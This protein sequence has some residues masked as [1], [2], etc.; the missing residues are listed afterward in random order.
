MHVCPECGVH[1]PDSR[2]SVHAE[3]CSY[4]IDGAPNEQQV[5]DGSGETLGRMTR[6]EMIAHLD[7]LAHEEHRNNLA[8][9]RERTQARKED[10]SARAKVAADRLRS[11]RDA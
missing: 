4:E 7:S 6:E 11:P 9:A 8:W 5:D 3:D 2:W 1:N 10:R